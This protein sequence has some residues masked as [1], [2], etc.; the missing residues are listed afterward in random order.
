MQVF[1]ISQVVANL[2]NLTYSVCYPCDSF[3]LVY[4]KQ[5]LPH[6]AVSF[7]TYGLMIASVDPIIAEY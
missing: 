1:S 7:L 5:T 4:L 6:N 2:M 3:S